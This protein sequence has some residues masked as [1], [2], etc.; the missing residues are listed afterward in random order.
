MTTDSL[1]HPTDAANPGRYPPIPPRSVLPFIPLTCRRLL[2]VGCAGGEFGLIVKEEFGCEVWGIDPSQEVVERARFHLDNFINE[3]FSDQA[4]LPSQYFDVVTFN[5]SLEHFTDTSLAL[6]TARKLV[7]PGGCLV[8]SIPN[9]RYI[10]NVLH[11]MMEQDWQ[12]EKQ[13]IRDSTH[14]RF[15]TKKSMVRTL[16][17]EGYVI[18]S[19]VGINPRYWIGRSLRPIVGIFGDWL[20]DM[21]FLQYVIVATPS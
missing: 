5:D 14:L 6:Q 20:E 12:Y 16:Q 4:E 11:L 21:N 10:E 3:P 19:I 2:D 1:S 18:Q 9:V 17:H 8:L 13:G 7:A 15:F